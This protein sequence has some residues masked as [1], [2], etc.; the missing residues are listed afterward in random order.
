MISYVVLCGNGFN[1][2]SKK[3]LLRVSGLCNFDLQKIDASNFCSFYLTFNK[4]NI[5]NKYLFSINFIKKKGR[6]IQEMHMIIRSK[7]YRNWLQRDLV[8]YISV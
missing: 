3:I 4:L 7:I 5:I 2:H 1:E 6:K 8:L